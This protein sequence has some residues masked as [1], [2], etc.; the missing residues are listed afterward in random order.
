MAVGAYVVAHRTAEEFRQGHVR[1]FA[2]DVPQRQVDARD[3]GG[4][5]NAVAVPEVLPVHHL[6]QMLGPRGIFAHEQVRHVFDRADDAA[7]MPL[8]R[9]LAP[10]DETGLI[11]DDF[12][13][14]PV[15]HPGMADKS[16]NS[17]DLHDEGESDNDIRW[18]MDSISCSR[19]PAATT[20]ML[21]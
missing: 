13:K 3:G 16:F 2:D 21:S 1:H 11:G 14:H 19:L 20:A 6:P 10:A 17:S 18:A 12:H 4:A 5:H 9:R 7:R 15:S 8:Q